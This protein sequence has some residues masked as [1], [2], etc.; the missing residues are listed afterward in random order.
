MRIAIVAGFLL[1]GPFA[2]VWA[3]DASYRVVEAKSSVRVHVGKSGLL[4]FAGH[5]HEVQAPVTGTVTV[6]PENLGA[7]SVDLTFTS[8]RLGVLPEGDA[9]RVEEI[10]RGPSVLDALRFP[11]IR[12][13]SKMVGGRVVSPGN[14]EL[15]PGKS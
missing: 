8:A 4:S 14:Y 5:L 3:A 7:S 1:L 13:R 10:M 2:G 6:N 12:F 11:K 9:P 15:T